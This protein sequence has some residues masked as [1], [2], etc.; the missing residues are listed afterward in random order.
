[1]AGTNEKLVRFRLEGKADV[2]N[3]E[4]EKLVQFLEAG[5]NMVME[6]TRAY[7]R[8]APDQDTSRVYVSMIAGG[9]H[10]EQS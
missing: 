10:A 7:P 4:A 9:N 8:R 1:M 2:I 6:W 3:Q 5:G